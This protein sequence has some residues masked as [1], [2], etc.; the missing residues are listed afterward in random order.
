[1]TMARKDWLARHGRRLAEV[2]GYTAFLAGFVMITVD[3]A[4]RVTQLLIVVPL[5]L[6]GGIVSLHWE[7][8]RKARLEAA[9]PPEPLRS[10]YLR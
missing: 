7:H 10:H 4:R 6:V 3:P 8:R 2:I 1:M 5:T 9:Q